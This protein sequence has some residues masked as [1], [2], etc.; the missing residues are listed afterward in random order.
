MLYDVICGTFFIVNAP[1][2][3]F[4]SLTDEQIQK[5]IEMYGAKRTM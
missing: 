4:E 2:E 1:G 5:Y 3:D